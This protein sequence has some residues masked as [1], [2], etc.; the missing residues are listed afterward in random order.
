MTTVFTVWSIQEDGVSENRLKQPKR[1]G[2]QIYGNP[3][4]CKQ[5]LK[6]LGWSITKWDIASEDEPIECSSASV[7]LT[8][9]L[10]CRIQRSATHAVNISDGKDESH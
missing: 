4:P 1:P 5:S 8:D 9:R 7:N 3:K 10:D 6:N 2:Y